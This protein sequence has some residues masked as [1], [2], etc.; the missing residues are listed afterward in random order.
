MIYK[1]TM[2]IFKILKVLEFKLSKLEKNKRS[3]SIGRL[4]N[5]FRIYLVK[6]RITELKKELN[7]RKHEIR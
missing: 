1:K 2:P 7:I 3:T 6:D 4:I 5:N